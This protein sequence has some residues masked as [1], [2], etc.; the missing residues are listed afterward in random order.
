[1]K[2]NMGTTD[3]IF[4]RFARANTIVTLGSFDGIHKGH[5]KIFA[6][7]V[8]KAAEIGGAPVAITFDPHPMK[9]LMPER[10]LK[11]IT[12][13]A[14]K[15]KIIFGTGIRDIVNMDFSPEFAHT[16]AEEFVRDI[17]VGLLNAKWVIVGHNCRFGY[18]RKG[19]ADLLRKMGRKYGFRVRVIN[20]ASLRGDVISSSRVRSA[21]SGGR[22]AEAAL[23]LGR[24]YHMDGA[25]IKGAGRGKTLLNVPTANLDTQNELI[26]R[27]GVYAVKVSFGEKIYDGAAN[28]GRNPTFKEDI[29]SYEIHIL[30]FKRNI[31]G[32]N[33]RVHFI[34][35]IRDERKFASVEDLRTQINLDLDAA[36]RATRKSRTVLYL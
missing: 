20:Y 33:L 12:S 10:R 25:V 30:D 9:A 28:I 29:M 32:R 15:E 17:L 36:R 19:N 4:S 31:L 6:A 8:K 3:N 24:A 11:L 7:V 34:D 13:A 1:M 22:V 27:E 2:K 26:P 14:D 16:E 5:Q 23:M 35:R 18:N 21:V